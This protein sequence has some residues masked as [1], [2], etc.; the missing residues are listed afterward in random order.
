MVMRKRI[1]AILC[2]LGLCGGYFGYNMGMRGADPCPP[3]PTAPSAPAA[4]VR[5]INSDPALQEAWETIAAAYTEKTGTEVQIIPAQQQGEIVPTLFTVSDETELEQIA[6]VCYELS[7]E[8]AAHHVQDRYTLKSGK[9]MCGLPLEVEGYGLIYNS[10][11]LRDAGITASDVRSFSKLT[12]VVN[13]IAGNSALKFEPFACLD[14]NSA[15]I[16]LLASLPGDIRPFWDLYIRNTACSDVTAEGSGP[17][18]EIAE[19]KAAFCIGSTK[20]YREMAAM[21][22]GNLNIMPL[23][24]GGE[25]ETAQGLCL[26]VDTYLCVRNDVEKQDLEATLDF[27]DY[28]VHTTGSEAPVIDQLGI[29]TPYGTAKFQ[30]SPLEKTLR[31][32]IQSGKQLLVF[33]AL[34]APEGLAE[35]LKAYA[36]E[37]TDENWAIVTDI[38]E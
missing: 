3:A 27:L 19:W 23:Y 22:E 35:A 5:F 8:R 17:M 31:E 15:A 29:F 38:L 24:I 34:D 14:M 6:D 37:P 32:Q 9:K 11:L 20:E 13:I 10:K 2:L 12:E 33:S 28:L 30:S 18:T 25:K 1:V 7:A 21:S 16:D 26:R 36:A 4:Q